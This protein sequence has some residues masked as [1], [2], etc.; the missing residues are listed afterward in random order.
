MLK[1]RE[2]PYNAERRINPRLEH[3]HIRVRAELTCREPDIEAGERDGVMLMGTQIDRLRLSERSQ[4]EVFMGELKSGEPYH[5]LFI[6]RKRRGLNM[7]ELFE[8]LYT[9]QDRLLDEERQRLT[10]ERRA[11]LETHVKKILKV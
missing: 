1:F 10:E 5:A 6:T 4:Q 9:E 8:S 3:T 11:Y 7:Q 2:S